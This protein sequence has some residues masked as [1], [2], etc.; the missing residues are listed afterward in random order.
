MIGRKILG[1]SMIAA[2]FVGLG[3]ACYSAE[4]LMAFIVAVV[5]VLIV[6]PIFYVGIEL[7]LGK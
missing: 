4:V 2:P 7:V 6:V 5:L 1:V 3:A